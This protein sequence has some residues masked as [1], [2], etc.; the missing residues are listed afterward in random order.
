VRRI[1]LTYGSEGAYLEAAERLADQARSTSIFDAVIVFDDIELL[2]VS[3]EWKKW[4]EQLCNQ[5]GLLRYKQAAKAFLL[6]WATNEYSS[7]DVLFLYADPGCE[8]PNNL[9]SVSRLRFLLT[10]AQ[11]T[12]GLAEQ[13]DYPEFQYTHLRM[14][15]T[16]D[17]QRQHWL[18][19]QVQNTFFIVSSNQ[20]TRDFCQ[21][22]VDTIDPYLRLW[23]DPEVNETQLSGFIEHRR[24]QSIFSLLW[25]ING[26]STKRPYWEHGG[27]FGNIRGIAIPI[28]TI[29]NRTGKSLLPNYQNSS[30]FALLGLCI[31]NLSNLTRRF[32]I[33]LAGSRL[34]QKVMAVIRRFL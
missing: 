21:E 10:L 26:F 15:M 8:I 12:G 13:L 22:W 18:S 27:R 33:Y 31:S 5:D 34:K 7:S 9:I 28:Q 2:A 20:K 1:F 30:F 6:L 24:D 3:Q 17:P 14:L 23:K 16:L 29:R 32:R 25:K 19:G 11:K 4:S